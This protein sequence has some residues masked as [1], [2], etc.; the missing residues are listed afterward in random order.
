MTPTR[1]IFAFLSVS[2]AAFLLS[3]CYTQVGSTR[4]EP[5]IGQDDSYA[6]GAYEDSTGEYPPD[7]YTEQDYNYDRD[8]LYYD[9]YYPSTFVNVPSP[10]ALGSYGWYGSGYNPFWCGTSY[11]TILFGWPGY[12]PPWS[13]YSPYYS[14]WWYSPVYYGGGGYTYGYSDTR[15]H[16]DRRTIGSTRGGSESGVGSSRGGT[17]TLPTATVTR[18]GG[19]S[20]SAA[21]SSSGTSGPAV[22]REGSTGRTRSGSSGGVNNGGRSSRG[23]SRESTTRGGS[24]RGSPET[25]SAPPARVSPPQR[26]APPRSSG[27]ESTYSP[28]PSRPAPPPSSSG[29]S[30]GTRSSGG[31]RDSGPRR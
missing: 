14:S 30:G 28:P 1:K 21:P 17:T 3:G 7:T 2:F 13:W 20:T 31:S 29:G 19:S 12:Y 26:S 22:G 4:P 23:G 18:G 11:P 9:Y 27:G 10:F 24:R 15:G 8:R 6:E 25:R 5:A 16:G